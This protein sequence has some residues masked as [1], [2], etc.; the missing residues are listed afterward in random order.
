MKSSNVI[1]LNDF[2]STYNYSK[3]C[4]TLCT[5]QLARVNKRTITIIEV[6]AV[7]AEMRHSRQR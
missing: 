6:E 1:H 3:F 4:S 5:L 2:M 7:K